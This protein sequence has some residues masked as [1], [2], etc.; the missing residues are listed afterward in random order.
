[1]AL[2]LYMDVQ[3]PAAITEGLRRRG[4]DVLTSQEDGT[5]EEDDATLLVRATELERVLFTQ[6][7]DFLR[8]AAEWQQ[9]GRAFPGVVFAHQQGVSIGPLI[10]DLELLL[11]CCGINELESRVTYLPLS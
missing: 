2:A 6:D 7:S 1:M 10:E 3:I 11:T 8:I 5:R 9:T 4:I